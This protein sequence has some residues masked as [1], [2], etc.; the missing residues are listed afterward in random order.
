MSYNDDSDLMIDD[1]EAETYKCPTSF[2]VNRP[3]LR[4]CLNVF[5]CV[6]SCITLFNSD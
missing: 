5:E 6:S 4:T 3:F 2:V 1:F